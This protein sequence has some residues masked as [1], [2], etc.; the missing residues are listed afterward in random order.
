M[1]KEATKAPKE[2]S[3]LDGKTSM[4]VNIFLRQFKGGGE[5]VVTLI[6]EGNSKQLEWD[7]LR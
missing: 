6:K 1:K 2:I 5:E 3:I 7:R 4:N